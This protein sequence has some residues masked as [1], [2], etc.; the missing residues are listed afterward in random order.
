ME[1][2]NP[3]NDSNNDLNSNHTI[4]NPGGGRV[5]AGLA[6][7][8]CFLLLAGQNMLSNLVPFALCLYGL[9]VTLKRSLQKPSEMRFYREQIAI[10]GRTI[11]ANEV[12]IIMIRGYFR[13][14]LGIK[15]YGKRIVPLHLC[16]RF[17]DDED[18][19]MQ[20]LRQWAAANE[21]KVAR[22]PFMRWV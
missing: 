14:V 15:P 19:G 2:S 1:S 20:A 22:K 16:F 9:I 13:P 3:I 17:A 11:Q 21:V 10:N 12:K 4:K 5:V 8:C 7:M 18:A 6:F